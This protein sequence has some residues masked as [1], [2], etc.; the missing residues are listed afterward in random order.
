LVDVGDHV[1]EGDVLARLDDTDAQSQVS[2]A[3]ISLRQAELQLAQ[4]AADP[5]ASELAAARA[6]L[7]SAEAG[8][9]DLTAPASEQDLVGAREDLASAQAA[10]A[11][12]LAGPSE[13]EVTV[14]KA[15]MEKARIE[16]EYAQAEYDKFAWRQGYGASSQAADLQQATI[17]YATAKAN[18]EITMAD[19]GEEELASARAQV[20]QARAALEQVEQGPG[21]EELAAAEGKVAEAKAAREDLLA[22]SSVEDLES[23]ELDLEQARNTLR[24]AERELAQTELRAP[25]AGVITA[26]DASTGESVG[27]EAFVTLADLSAPRVRFWMDE[28]DLTSMAVGRRVSIVFDA[29]PGETFTGEVIRVE[30]ALVTVDNTTAVQ[31]LATIDLGGTT[32]TLLSGMTADEVEVIAAE[33]R[34]ALLVPVQALQTLSPGQHVVR[35][36]KADGSLEVRPVQVGLKDLVYAEILFGLE[37][38]EEVVTDAISTTSSQRPSESPAAGGPPSGGFGMPGG[39]IPGG[40]MPRGPGG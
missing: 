30:P 31:G 39:G 16:L 3:R 36:A 8:L 37:V 27:T 21:A 2:D 26:F 33:T 24:A 6:T 28:T 34:D 5:D 40:G 14:A 20:A 13:H 35:V 11:E 10:L 9:A 25:F 7:A 32:A 15:D 29:L 23:A 17:D 19:P 18:Y 12:L 38:G 1:T 4:L 22:G